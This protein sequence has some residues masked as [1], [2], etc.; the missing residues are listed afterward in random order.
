MEYIGKERKYQS[1]IGEGMSFV[2][3]YRKGRF[4][5]DSNGELITWDEDHEYSR[6]NKRL[7]SPMKASSMDL[8]YIMLENELARNE[9]L[10]TIDW[11]A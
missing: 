11:E 4:L 7:I 5:R 1:C 6:N 8:A 9:G 3:D 2:Y 10:P